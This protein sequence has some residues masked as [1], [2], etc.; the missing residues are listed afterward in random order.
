MLRYYSL[1]FLIYLASVCSGQNPS[2]R[3]YNTDNGLPTNTIYNLFNTND[4]YLY[5]GTDLG[6]V[7]FNGKRSTLYDAHGLSSKAASGFV[8][9]P[10][11]NKVYGINFTGQLLKWDSTLSEIDTPHSSIS[12]IACDSLGRV[13]ICGDSGLYRLDPTKD[14][15]TEVTE[16]N[17]ILRKENGLYTGSPYVTQD[18]VVWFT[19]IFS[20]YRWDGRKLTA[21]KGDFNI[22]KLDYA[23]SYLLFESAGEWYM[24]HKLSQQLLKLKGDY[25]EAITMPGLDVLPDDA[26]LTNLLVING[27]WW[28]CTYNGVVH[29]DPVSGAAVHWFQDKVITDVLID[30]EGNYWFS[31]LYEGILACSDMSIYHWRMSEDAHFTMSA[32]NGVTCLIAKQ[33]GDLFLIDSLGQSSKIDRKENADIQFMGWNPFAHQYEVASNGVLFKVADGKTA[34]QPVIYSSLRHIVYGREETIYCSRSGTFSKQIQRGI[35]VTD[36]LS[37]EVSR[38]AEFNSSLSVLAVASQRGL[39]LFQRGPEGFQ[40]NRTVFADSVIYALCRGW[41]DDEWFFTTVS[42]IIYSVSGSDEPQVFYRPKPGRVIRQIIN[43]GGRVWVSTNNGVLYFDKLSVLPHVLNR[44]DGLASNTI[45]YISAVGTKIYISTPGG[46]NWFPV[47]IESNRTTPLVKLQYVSINNERRQLYS[48]LS[49]FDIPYNGTLSLGMDVVG[50]CSESG[51][52][53]GYRF[54]SEGEEWNYVP[55][56]NSEFTFTGFPPGEWA[57]ELIVRDEAGNVTPVFRVATFRV[58]PPFWQRWWFYV[59]MVAAFVLLCVLGFSFYIRRLRNKQQQEL[60][61]MK[62]LNDLNLSQQTAL[63]AQMSPHFI[64][65]VLNSIKGFIYQNDKKNATHYLNSF[66]DLVRRVLS[67]SGSRLIKLSEELE[68]IKLYV[69]LET[70]LLNP[71][72]ALE[73]T[74]DPTIDISNLRIPSL[75][76]QPFVENAFKHGLALKNGEKVLKIIVREL[77]EGD[78]LE[79]IIEDNGIGRKAASAAKDRR[80]SSTSFALGATKRRLGLLNSEKKDL[81]GLQIIDLYNEQEMPLGTRVILKIAV[82]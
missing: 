20:V 81:V 71:P 42:G 30:H 21:F 66:S 15:V 48:D 32:S 51:Y 35:V 53:V 33:N 19:G 79:I 43:S 45:E 16:V 59:G 57:L 63:S 34:P 23:L 82:N 4:G 68:I 46:I 70:S 27:T 65:N 75:I 26:K 14:V 25:F 54:S 17:D 74:I 72:F 64:F 62:L 60:R 7:R 67:M 5:M 13:W 61:Q 12:Q 47:N 36:T 69:D 58:I 77:K 49:N 3:K 29:L 1:F 18:S 78:I 76:V 56:S 8:C 24:I 22:G 38:L 41:K 11:D 55:F 40:I 10:D 80:S 28:I 73:M 37:P 39:Q 2:A 44:N 52:D 31:T 9:S 6:L 50:F